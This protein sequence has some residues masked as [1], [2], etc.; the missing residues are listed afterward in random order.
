MKHNGQIKNMCKGCYVQDICIYIKYSET[1]PCTM[2]I[3]KMMCNVKCPE[4]KN[5]RMESQI[6]RRKDIRKR[7]EIDRGI[8][9]EQYK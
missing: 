7:I 9:H 5:F 4:R 2:C 6:K 8:T 3:I 1:C